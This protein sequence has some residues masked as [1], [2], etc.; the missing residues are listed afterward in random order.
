M[1]TTWE[2]SRSKVL[3]RE[4]MIDRPWE[5]EAEELSAA[6]SENLLHVYLR[7]AHAAYMYHCTR[8]LVGHIYGGSPLVGQHKVDC[9]FDEL[10]TK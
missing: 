6:L 2:G 9:T 7:A 4:R 1:S 8:N 10:E 3:T 5:F